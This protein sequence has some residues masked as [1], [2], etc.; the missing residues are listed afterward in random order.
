M[1]NESKLNKYYNQI[2]EKLD[3]LIPIKWNKIAMYTEEIGDVSSVSFYFYTDNCAKIHHSGNIPVEYNVNE[4]VFDSLINELMNINKRLWQE[5]NNTGEQP[6]CSFT[7]FLDNKWKFKVE[8]EYERDN[9]VDTYERE[10]I[11]AY[12]KLSIVPEDGYAKKILNE[13]LKKDET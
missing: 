2:A 6:W 7:F 12:E 1:L 4:D 9:E 10:I 5:F 13:Y 11:W 8:Y 3:E